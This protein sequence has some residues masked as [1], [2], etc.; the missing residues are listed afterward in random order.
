MPRPGE[1]GRKVGWSNVMLWIGC[2]GMMECYSE[3]DGDFHFFVSARPL[4]PLRIRRHLSGG[5]HEGRDGSKRPARD[6]SVADACRGENG[7][8]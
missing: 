5:E 2:T 4:Q 6:G 7:R 3:K 1:I 8:R